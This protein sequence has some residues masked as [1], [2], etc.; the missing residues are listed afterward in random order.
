MK[1][2]IYKKS[3]CPHGK[4]VPLQLQITSNMNFPCRIYDNNNPID[5]ANE[6]AFKLFANSYNL[7]E[8]AGGIVINSH[9][10]VLMIFR[11]GKWDFPK[12]K[13]ETGENPADA[14]IREVCE[15]TGLE[16][17]VLGKKLPSSFHTYQLN[18][19]KILKQTHWYAMQYSSDH[20][21]KPQEE[22]DITKVEW[23]DIGNVGRKLK[24]SYVSLQFLWSI[25]RTLF[26]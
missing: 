16:A 17:P 9:N 8:A 3:C 21:L 26:C 11:L 6:K 4:N 18:G 1:L 13:I 14:A 12:G 5:I 24:D 10:Q 22:E 2:Q 15:E 7:I 23:I 25:V 20:T 19:E